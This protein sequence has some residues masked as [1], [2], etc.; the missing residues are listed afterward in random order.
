MRSL[1]R[2]GLCCL[3]I[4][5]SGGS[6]WTPSA[7]ASGP[8]TSLPADE[9]VIATA[10]LTAMEAKAAQ[11]EPRE[12]CFLYTELLHEWTEVAGRSLAAGDDNSAAEAIQHADA[13]A[14]RLKEAINRD[15]KRLKNAELLMEHSVHR[16]SDIMR[17]S[18]LEQ[19]DSMQA[20]MRR[21]SSVHDD[22]LAAVFA[23]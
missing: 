12:R 18:T 14:A 5:L 6:L 23:H 7:Y 13:N 22:L 17:V 15:S 3:L 4:I 19:R 21:V 9:P 8:G 10:A 20:V 16:L 2:F 1:G 11:A